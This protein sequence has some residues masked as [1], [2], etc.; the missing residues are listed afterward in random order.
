MAFHDVGHVAD[1]HVLGL[2]GEVEDHVDVEALEDLGV[3]AGADALEDGVCVSV[4]L[5]AV[6]LLEQAVV[7]ALHAH[8]QALHHALQLLEVAGNQV[9]GVGLAR[10]LLDVEE[11]ARLADGLG[12]L[13]HEDG[14][15][16]AADVHAVEVVAHI[17]QHAH[18]CA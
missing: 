6:H 11:V 3:C 7:E 4:L 9:V 15:G 1:E 5:K 8:A 16:A 13:V 12:Q 17:C 10:D 18:L 14:G 2:R